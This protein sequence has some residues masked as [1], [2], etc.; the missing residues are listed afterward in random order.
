M[1]E[2]AA[3]AAAGEEEW[4]KGIE[5]LNLRGD[6]KKAKLIKAENSEN[7]IR[8]WSSNKEIEQEKEVKYRPIDDG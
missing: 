5:T 1:N 4:S 7:V 3:A 8:R 6:F 2:Q